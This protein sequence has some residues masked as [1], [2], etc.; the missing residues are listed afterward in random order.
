ALAAARD[1]AL[2]DSN[3]VILV[4]C[5]ELCSLHFAYGWNPGA[6]VANG[7]FAD[8]AAAAVIA[9][10]PAKHNGIKAGWKLRSTA[11]RLLPDSLNDMTWT[12]GDNGFKMT[13]SP[14]VPHLIRQHLRPWCEQWLSQQKLAISQVKSW[15]VHPG[16]PKILSA[17]EHSLG[18]KND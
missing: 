3:A 15:A 5:A 16:G 4:C 17:V 6:L 9:R 8:G 7:L 18:L 13:L 14:Q 10:D 2:A 11:S 12:I 1:A